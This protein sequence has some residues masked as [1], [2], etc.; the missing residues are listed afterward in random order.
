MDGLRDGNENEGDWA[1]NCFH[2]FQLQ[3]MGNLLLRNK[4]SQIISNYVCSKLQKTN[5]LINSTGKYCQRE[6]AT[7]ALVSVAHISLLKSIRA[8]SSPVLGC[9]DDVSCSRPRSAAAGC[10]AFAPR[11]PIANFAVN[12]KCESLGGYC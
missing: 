6:E 1:L 7:S 12:W 11:L 3:L 2:L 8:R 4:Y 10:T 9:S 5:L